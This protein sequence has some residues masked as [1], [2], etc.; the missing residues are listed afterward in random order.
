MG[1]AL[2]GGDVNCSNAARFGRAD[3]HAAL[4]RAITSI[5]RAEETTLVPTSWRAIV[6]MIMRGR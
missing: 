2:R 4:E 1:P 6:I 3:A 5:S